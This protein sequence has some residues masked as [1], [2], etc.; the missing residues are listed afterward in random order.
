MIFLKVCSLRKVKERAN[1]DKEEEPSEHGTQAMRS[2]GLIHRE[3]SLGH[4]PCRRIVPPL[5]KEGQ[6]FITISTGC[7]GSVNSIRHVSEK[8]AGFELSAVKTHSS[9][10]MGPSGQ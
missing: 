2:L 6:H 3:W 9:R 4:K 7:G 8:E 5:T 10:A 1:Q